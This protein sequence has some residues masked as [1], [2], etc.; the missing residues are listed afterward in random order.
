MKK[1]KR[2]LVF[3]GQGCQFIGMGKDLYAKSK[4]I[5]DEA[6]QTLNQNLSKLMFEGDEKEL[7]RTSNAQPAI[8]THCMALYHNIENNS[9]FD[10]TLGHSLG[11]YT[12][13]CVSGAISFSDALKLVK[14]RGEIMEETIKDFEMC[15]LMPCSIE[16]AEE[17]CL[18][19]E[20]ET[21]K[22][23][24]IAGINSKTQ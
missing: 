2:V 23:C 13:L 22:V 19:T 17:I 15:V 3:P 24:D 4:K 16:T 7:T 10:C 8:L 12:S 6:D 18:E 9:S 1:I 11:E 20:K 21:K 5:F 14:K